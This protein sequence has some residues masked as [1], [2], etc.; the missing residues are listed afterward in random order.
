MSPKIVVA[1]QMM[2]GAAE[3]IEGEAPDGG[4]AAVFED[5][6]ETGYF[7]AV[8]PSVAEQP[9]QDALH[10]YNVMQV[11][12]RAVP[13]TVEIGWTS[14]SRK[15]ALMINGYTHAVFD[16]EKRQGYC[17]TG[18]PQAGPLG[19]WSE[20]GHGWNDAATTGFL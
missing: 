15:A 3:V 1:R 16:F 5:D 9:I 19:S 4:F 2:V 20:D 12:D 11:S 8:D 17:R 14:D 13:I 10:I 6:G 18:F 7:Y